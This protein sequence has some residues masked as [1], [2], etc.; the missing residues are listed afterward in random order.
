[1]SRL[2]SESVNRSWPMCAVH[3]RR[4][5]LRYRGYSLSGIVMGA[6]DYAEILS[7]TAT[8]ASH[9]VRF[10]TWPRAEFH[11]DFRFLVQ[12][13]GCCSNSIEHSV[14]PFRNCSL[15]FSRS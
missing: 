11:V 15:P 7:T 8:L 3:L 12:F 1:M 2:T 4:Q 6:I 10:L 13:S 5:I 14:G 9:S